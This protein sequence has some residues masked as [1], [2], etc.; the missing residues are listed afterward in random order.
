[1][2]FSLFKLRAHL[3]TLVFIFLRCLATL[4]RYS[5]GTLARS[6]ICFGRY[7]HQRHCSYWSRA[8]GTTSEGSASRHA[9][10]LK[11]PFYWKFGNL[12]TKVARLDSSF[13]R[14][15]HCNSRNAL[16]FRS[17]EV[18]RNAYF[19]LKNFLKLTCQISLICRSLS[20][21]SNWF[22]RWPRLVVRSYYEG[23]WVE[24]LIFCDFG[25]FQSVKSIDWNE[26]GYLGRK[27]CDLSML[28]QCYAMIA[29]FV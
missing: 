17:Q 2:V 18:G 6:V 3:K 7:F 23:A 19:P 24:P 10:Q 5:A 21:V 28:S 14:R 1:M 26:G 25:Q 11:S 9:D 13:V 15:T 29:T 27:S 20:T 4:C 8:L 12:A 16:K 22:S